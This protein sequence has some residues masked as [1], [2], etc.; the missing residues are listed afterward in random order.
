M[1]ST[2][3]PQCWQYTKVLIIIFILTPWFCLKPISK[4]PRSN[5]FHALRVCLHVSTKK[6]LITLFSNMQHASEKLCTHSPS[7]TGKSMFHLCTWCDF[8]SLELLVHF[9]L[10]KFA[11][12]QQ[13]WIF[14][15]LFTFYVFVFVF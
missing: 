2:N 4:L 14:L 13:F 6:Y 5:C 1:M 11:M 10:N 12:V 8:S 3:C 15:Y 7:N 9:L